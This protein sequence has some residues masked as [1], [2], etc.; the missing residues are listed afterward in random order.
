MNEYVQTSEAMTIYYR[1]VVSK[2]VALNRQIVLTGRKFNEIEVTDDLEEKHN[3]RMIED[4]NELHEIIRERFGLAI[5]FERFKPV[6][7]YE[8]ELKAL[9]NRECNM[10]ISL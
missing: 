6:D 8:A 2:H 9:A 7:E 10:A 5:D 1:T 3:V 4:D